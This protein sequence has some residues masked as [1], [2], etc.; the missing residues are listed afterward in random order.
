MGKEFAARLDAA[1]RGSGLTKRTLA[2]SVN[3]VPSAISQW[4]A[5]KSEPDIATKARLAERL[6]VP[7]DWLLG[8]SSEVAEPAV[9]Y[10]APAEVRPAQ[11]FFAIPLVAEQ[12]A[13]GGPVFDPVES[14]RSWYSFRVEF[15]EHVLGRGR[16]TDDERRLVLVRVSRDWKGESMEPTIRRGALLAI[17]RGP[18]A[19]GHATAESGGIYM[20][21]PPGEDGVTIKRVFAAGEYLIL[22]SDNPAVQQREPHEPIRARGLDLRRVL[23]GRVRWLSQELD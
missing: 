1:I 22:W 20:V 19:A 9:A 14:A 5:G 6:N 13:A 8:L 3:R 16:R 10:D 21:R 17:D 7:R 11:E 12:V 23:V 18:G 15:L 4:L 2:A